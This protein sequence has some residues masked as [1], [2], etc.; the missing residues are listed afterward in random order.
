MWYR[1]GR[2]REYEAWS[3]DDVDSVH[4]DYQRHL[5][6][7]WAFP[8]FEFNKMDAWSTFAQAAD[9]HVWESLGY[10][11]KPMDNGGG[12]IMGD[13]TTLY[14]LELYE[15]LLHTG[16]QSY[17]KSKWASAKNATAWMISNAGNF[18]LPQYLQTT[19]DHF[20]FNSR[21]TVVY[22]CHI[23]LTALKAVEQMASVI[24]DT[25]TAATA[26]AA[27]E[28]GQKT[29]LTPTS[30]GGPLW[31]ESNGFFLAHSETQTQVFTD[32]LYGAQFAR[33]NCSAPRFTSAW[34]T[35]Q[36]RTNACA[37]LL[38]RLLDGQ[39]QLRRQPLGV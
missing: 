30:A 17:V 33:L 28:A 5:L 7:L 20:G 25:E 8:E 16:N 4:N 21:K 9:G 3:C 31:N 15:I 13:T 38:E 11:G 12:R 26:L 34:P 36:I 35:L 32:S 27:F 19:Y 39:R 24:G 18:T 1:D 22:N 2:L 10:T 37:S 6:Y 14:L 23:Y 29:L